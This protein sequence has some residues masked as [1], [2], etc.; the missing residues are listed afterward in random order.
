MRRMD[1]LLPGLLLGLLLGA[2]GGAGAGGRSHPGADCP[3]HL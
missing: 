3:G 2:C 1:M